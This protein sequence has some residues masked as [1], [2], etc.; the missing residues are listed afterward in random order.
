LVA[1]VA[2]QPSAL[3]VGSELS[4]SLTYGALPPDPRLQICSGW[5]IC[6]GL[7]HAR[8]GGTGGNGGNSVSAHKPLDQL[9]IVEDGGSVP[10]ITCGS[11]PHRLERVHNRLRMRHPPVSQL[12]NVPDYHQLGS[13]VADAD[14]AFVNMGEVEGSEDVGG[15]AGVLVSLVRPLKIL[16]VL[17]HVLAGPGVRSAADE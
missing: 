3:L 4:L 1:G 13:E 7:L 10:G 16:E 11:E 9:L 14:L 2:Y 17:D 15:V 6:S 12:L 8:A 5:S